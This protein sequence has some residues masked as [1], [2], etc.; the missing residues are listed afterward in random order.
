M[1]VIEKI[2]QEINKK[3]WERW[4]AQ[5]NVKREK[6]YCYWGNWSG[7]WFDWN[8]WPDWFDWFEWSDWSDWSDTCSSACSCPAGCCGV[9]VSE[10]YNKAT[11]KLKVAV[12]A[13]FC[14]QGG[15]NSDHCGNTMGGSASVYAC[16]TAVS[17]S[18]CGCEGN[19]ECGYMC[20]G[21]NEDVECS[22][23]PEWCDYP[24]KAHAEGGCSCG[25]LSADN[26]EVSCTTG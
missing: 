16:E 25:L 21:I 22:V 20:I 11:C 3:R 2:R 6:T 14:L 19:W 18:W 9:Y 5:Q 26:C 4:R 1:G 24:M 17:G 13:A 8:D 10:D 15:Y 23:P 7:N 12:T